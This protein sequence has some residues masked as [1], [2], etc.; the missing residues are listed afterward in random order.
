MAQMQLELEQ[1]VTKI[2]KEQ[3]EE[4]EKQ[5]EIKPS[6]TEEDMKS[7]L[8]EVVQEVKASKK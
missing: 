2:V 3:E 4:M 1:R 5:T 6:L 8:N 7:Y